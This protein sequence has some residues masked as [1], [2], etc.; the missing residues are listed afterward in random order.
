LLL[1]SQHFLWPHNLIHQ[2]LTCNTDLVKKVLFIYN[3][4]RSTGKCN[5]ILCTMAIHAYM[6][7]GKSGWEKSTYFQQDNW[8]MWKNMGIP[9]QNYS[10]RFWNHS[11]FVDRGQPCGRT[12]CLLPSGKIWRQQVLPSVSFLQLY[13][14]CLCRGKCLSRAQQVFT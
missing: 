5:T 10:S 13:T 4:Q 7:T 9:H 12:C 1:S 3:I 6:C 8:C 14:S 11:V 2:I